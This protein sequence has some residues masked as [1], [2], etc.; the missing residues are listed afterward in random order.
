M[1]GLGMQELVII[2]VIALIIFIQFHT[3]L[4]AKDEKNYYHVFLMSFFLLLAAC[5][6]GPDRKAMMEEI[7]HSVPTMTARH[8]A[9]LDV[10]VLGAYLADLVR[11]KGLR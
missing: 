3:M 8:P 6:T 10:G 7:R 1:F 4:H 11:R 5:E 2:L 9:Q